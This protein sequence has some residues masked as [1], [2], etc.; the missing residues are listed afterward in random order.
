DVK[1]IA[2]A[3]NGECLSTEYINSKTHCSKG[4]E[5]LASLHHIKISNSWCSKYAKVARHSIE[6]CEDLCHKIITKY[7]GS[8]SPIRKSDFLKTPKYLTGLELNILY[9]DY[10]FVIKVQGI[11]HERQI[12]FFYPNFEDFEK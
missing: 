7:L 2:F 5:F 12:K 10:S 6:K 1:Q 9:Y 4:H 11:Q 3:Q 8:P